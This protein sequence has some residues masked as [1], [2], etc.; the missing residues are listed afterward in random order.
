LTILIKQPAAGK[1][2]IHALVIG[3]GDYPYLEDGAIPPRIE[4]AE[5]GQL[6]SPPFSAAAIS[7]WLLRSLSPRQDAV[8]ASVDV[9]CSGEAEFKDHHGEQVMPEPATLPNV[10]AAVKEWY[11]RLNTSPENIGFFYFCGHGLTSGDVDSL[12]VQEFGE[13]EHDP[14]SVG[15]VDATAFIDGMRKCAAKRQ[16]FLL[17][18]CRTAPETY[19][20]EFGPHRGVPL[21]SATAHAG[22]GQVNQVVIWGSELGLPAYGRKG[23]PSVFLE[24]FLSSVRGASAVRDLDTADWEVQCAKLAEGMNA[25]VSRIIGKQRQFVTPGRLSSGF[26]LHVIDGVPIVPVEIAC[27]PKTRAPEVELRCNSGH[28]RPPGI[29]GNWHLDLPYGNYQV[30]AIEASTG[31]HLD[32]QPCPANPPMA[33]VIVSV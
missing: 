21:I 24:A 26:P 17:D 10:R 30:D 22:L 5:M 25:Y 11:R 31:A 15:A 23:K 33:S 29:N 27:K 20:R 12:L 28:T 18:A 14:F 19:L 6:S 8:L 4:T 16:L 1:A 9:L 2:E 13:D 32:T 7:E 3:V